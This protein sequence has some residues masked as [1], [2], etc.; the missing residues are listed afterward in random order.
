MFPASRLGN[1]ITYDSLFNEVLSEA[2]NEVIKRHEDWSNNK[3]VEVAKKIALAAIK[4]SML[5]KDSRKVIIFNPAEAIKFEGETGPYL[6]YVCTRCISILKKADI[7]PKVIMK[8]DLSLLKL[9]LE[10]EII[11]LLGQLDEKVSIAAEKY[12]VHVVLKYLIDLCQAFNNYYSAN[13]ILCGDE[14]L[15]IARLSL[16]M[17][18]LKILK[19]GLGLIGIETMEEM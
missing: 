16:V 10:F 7:N 14:D 19:E 18:L 2:T 6:Q 8:A 12:Q 11:K 5:F 17:A 4:F 13:R 15:K 3:I 1:I 9:P